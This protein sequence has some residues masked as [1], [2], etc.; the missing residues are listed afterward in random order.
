MLILS[1]QLIFIL[2]FSTIP[3]LRHYYTPQ[4]RWPFSL[5]PPCTTHIL[6]SFLIY[7]SFVT[8]FL[9]LFLVR[10]H[11]DNITT[12]QPC[13]GRDDSY[14]HRWVSEFFYFFV[15]G[16]IQAHFREPQDDDD[17]GTRGTTRRKGPRDVYASRGYRMFFLCFFFL[18]LIFLGTK[19][20]D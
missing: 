8:N 4:P 20:T 19:S 13:D 3:P 1:F 18:L 6:V 14:R 5:S 16:T 7:Y 12:H 15:L 17:G 11:H 2:V 10:Y 9:H